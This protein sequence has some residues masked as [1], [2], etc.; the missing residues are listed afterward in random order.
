MTY[1]YDQERG[2]IPG[3]CLIPNLVT[4]VYTLLMYV[5]YLSIYLTL[6]TPFTRE[7]VFMNACVYFIGKEYRGSR[8]VDKYP[9][10]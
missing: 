4:S 10:D 9:W 5:H 6:S 1:S 8:A 2:K 7:T 3:H